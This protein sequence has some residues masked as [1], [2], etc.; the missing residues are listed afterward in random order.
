MKKFLLLFALAVFSMSCDWEENKQDEEAL[1][2][3]EIVVDESAT[4]KDDTSTGGDKG[5]N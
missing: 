1:Y 4:D 2:E 3:K 5:G